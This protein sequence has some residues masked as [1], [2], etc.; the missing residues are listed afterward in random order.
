[1]PETLQYSVVAAVQTLWLAARR[2]AGA[3]LDFNSRASDRV[4]GARSTQYL[5]AYCLP[6]HWP[7]EEHLDPELHRHRW[8]ERLD[9]ARVIFTR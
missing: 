6:L 7:V 2:G 4:S 9:V 8:Q 1:M 3:W 5:E